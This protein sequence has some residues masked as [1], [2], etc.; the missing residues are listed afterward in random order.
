[1]LIFSHFIFYTRLIK[2]ISQDG[3]M[4]HSKGYGYSDVENNVKAN[5]NTVVR[6]ASISKPLTTAIAAKL[7][8][9]GKLDLDKP[10]DFYVKNLPNFKYNNKEVNYKYMFYY[11][12][13]LNY[14]FA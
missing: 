9:S 2:G 10:I 8:E 13:N 3:K 14:G 1:L 7:I 6:I 4:L 5:K 11:C 12:L